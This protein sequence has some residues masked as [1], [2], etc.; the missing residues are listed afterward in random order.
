[1]QDVTILS[2]GSFIFISAYTNRITGNKNRS[3]F[4]IFLGVEFPTTPHAAPY[5]QKKGPFLFFCD[6]YVSYGF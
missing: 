2:M 5:K 3:Y 1:M 4:K 6:V